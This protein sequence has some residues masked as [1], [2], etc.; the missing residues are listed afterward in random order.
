M[1]N[2]CTQVSAVAHSTLARYGLTKFF[3]WMTVMLF[4]TLPGLPE[5]AKKSSSFPMTIYQI[6]HFSANFP[7]IC[8]QLLVCS[9]KQFVWLIKS[10]SIKSTRLAF[11]AHTMS[12]K[13]HQSCSGSTKSLWL[14]IREKDLCVTSRAAWCHSGWGC[15]LAA[16]RVL[17]SN[18]RPL[19]VGLHVL[20]WSCGFP[21][22]IKK[23]CQTLR[24]CWP[25]VAA[26]L[27]TAPQD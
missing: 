3:L 5:G 17:C 6:V 26:H 9:W 27:V 4:C 21:L 18:L 14:G 22:T 1:T 23:T 13:E 7:V 15:G 8:F 20:F 12:G 10:W 19:N 24:S 2:A 16:G 25:N 11:E